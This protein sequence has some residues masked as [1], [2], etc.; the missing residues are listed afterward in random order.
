VVLVAVDSKQ[1]NFVNSDN[2]STDEFFTDDDDEND[3][4][5]NNFRPIQKS[6]LSSTK[7]SLHR[8]RYF[9]LEDASIIHEKNNQVEKAASFSVNKNQSDKTLNSPNLSPIRQD[10][11]VK[12][13]SVKKSNL[14]ANATVASSTSATASKSIIFMDTKEEEIENKNNVS[15][16][17]SIVD[18]DHHNHY[19][20]EEFYVKKLYHENISSFNNKREQYEEINDTYPNTQNTKNE[21]EKQSSFIIPVLS[22]SADVS[23]ANSSIVAKQ[24]SINTTNN[25]LNQKGLNQSSANIQ[26]LN[27][28]KP[29]LGCTT[30][31]NSMINETTTNQDSQDTG[32]QTISS[33]ANFC[34]SGANGSSSSSSSS[35]CTQPSLL[36]NMDTTQATLKTLSN[37]PPYNQQ[38]TNFFSLANNNSNNYNNRNVFSSFSS[39][40]TATTL[41]RGSLS[42][43]KSHVS[44]KSIMTNPTNTITSTPMNLGDE[45]GVVE[46]N[47]NYDNVASSNFDTH[48][49]YLDFNGADE[50]DCA[51]N[52]NNDNNIN[53]AA[54]AAALKLTRNKP[55]HFKSKI[56]DFT[57]ANR[58]WDA[59]SRM[60][61][62]GGSSVP[63]NNG[64]SLSF[65][66]VNNKVNSYQ[67]QNMM[68]FGGITTSKS[69]TINS[70]RPLKFDKNCVKSNAVNNNKLKKKASISL[71][72]LQNIQPVE[73]ST[74]EKLKSSF[75]INS[76]HVNNKKAFIKSNSISPPK[77]RIKHVSV[78]TLGTAS[79]TS[80][81]LGNITGVASR[82]LEKNTT[83]NN[84][85][86]NNVI[87]K[88]VSK[89]V[90]VSSNSLKNKS[91]ETIKSTANPE[92]E[93]DDAY[94]SFNNSPCSNILKSNNCINILNNQKFNSNTM[95]T[96]M[97]CNDFLAKKYEI[98][99]SYMDQSILMNKMSPSE[100]ARNVLEKAKHDLNDS[101]KYT[102]SENLNTSNDQNS[103]RL[104]LTNSNKR[105]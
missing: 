104:L 54:A 65:E 51:S 43:S 78:S 76:F 47:F 70:K 73:S 53:N 95:T 19:P 11:L 45:D 103:N 21:D 20:R 13:T 44:S 71:N 2:A 69:D 22:S 84:N 99:S 93:E 67:S 15:F 41:P 46:F 26:S 52:N 35:S 89:S 33:M 1:S 56:F 49:N 24:I 50:E 58:K 37:I 82:S 59:T 90:F 60:T 14:S 25:T 63:A 29:P 6:S 105:T 79:T 7:T 100:Y 40:Q 102:L 62:G 3:K 27:S 87:P 42:S 101:I 86:N 4:G 38:T 66:F 72:S 18:N 28:S 5:G 64:N 61:G 31:I 94:M 81:K 57:Y 23:R 83:F 16:S 91:Q 8:N 77:A 32:Y 55:V 68:V 48:H 97:S 92:E 10:E 36:I 12:V 96:S 98:D 17:E 34:A 75:R 80:S 39:V 74:P 9:C 88:I 30:M 85:N